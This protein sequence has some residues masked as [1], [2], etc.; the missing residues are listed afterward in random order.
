M[1]TPRDREGSFEPQVVRKRQ[2][3][4]HP[5]LEAKVLSTFASGMEI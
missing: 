2:T 4:L 3:S 5:E 1:L